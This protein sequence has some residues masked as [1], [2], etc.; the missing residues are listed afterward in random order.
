MRLKDDILRDINYSKTIE[1]QL[2]LNNELL[3]DMRTLL[4]ALTPDDVKAATAIKFDEGING[5]QRDP[6]DVHVMELPFHITL[7]NTLRYNNIN[8]L[9]DLGN[10]TIEELK[11]MS[12]IG[13]NSI[14]TI[15]KVLAEHGYNL[16]EYRK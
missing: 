10:M 16:Q 8:Y 11:K 3:L 9:S 14:E 1:A 7:K 4:A 15:K 6:N 12:G 2:R 13:Q 5:Q